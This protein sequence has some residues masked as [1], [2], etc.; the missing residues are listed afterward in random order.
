MFIIS[1]NITNIDHDDDDVKW[2]GMKKTILQQV[3]FISEYICMLT[4]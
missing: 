3:L 4:R 1:Y 2:N